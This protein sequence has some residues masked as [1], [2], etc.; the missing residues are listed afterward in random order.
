MEMENKDEKVI[1]SGPR[2]KSRKHEGTK[3]TAS[4]SYRDAARTG[5]DDRETTV[6]S[7]RN[8]K[9]PSKL[10]FLT[11]SQGKGMVLNNAAMEAALIKHGHDKRVRI[12][13]GARIEDMIKMNMELDNAGTMVITGGGNN[14]DTDE[15]KKMRTDDEEDFLNDLV[16]STAELITKY[17]KQDMSVV[18]ITPPIRETST[19]EAEQRYEIRLGE[20]CKDMRHVHIVPTAGFMAREITVHGWD[21]VRDKWLCNDGTHMVPEAIQKMIVEGLGQAK[22]GMEIDEG[23]TI[24]DIYDQLGRRKSTGGV[25]LC[26]GCG[27]HHTR[28]RCDKK[29]Y[30]CKFCGSNTHNE[31]ACTS[32]YRICKECGI[33]DVHKRRPCREN[34]WW[35]DQRRK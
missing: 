32:Q 9:R 12:M 13:P 31:E 15:W 34:A 16:D 20:V 19:K 27:G 11:D 33:A 14:L 1:A 8:K 2:N 5:A 24:R 28:E 25:K 23:D 22:V 17:T 30:Y 18:F 3:G 35:R 21:T 29:Q 4:T 6:K 10:A 7:R 26:Y